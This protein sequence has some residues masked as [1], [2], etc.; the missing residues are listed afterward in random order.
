[1][2]DAPARVRA[3]ASGTTYT[4]P[5]EVYERTT[6]VNTNDV[7]VQRMT[8]GLQRAQMAATPKEA[9]DKA[10]EVY[11][12][13]KALADDYAAIVATAK[14]VVEDAM[15]EADVARYDAEIATINRI[16]PTRSTSYDTKALDALCKSSPEIRAIL[17]PHRK[18]TIRAGSVRITPAKERGGAL[19]VPGHRKA[20]L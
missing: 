9:I 17:E 5:A 12:R 13:A 4:N 7:K 10:L 2:C 19:S 18:E 6:T 16:E 3:G 8:A 14:K 20:T 15:I 1:M 11:M